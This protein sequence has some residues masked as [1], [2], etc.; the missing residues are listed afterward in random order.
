MNAKATTLENHYPANVS[1]ILDSVFHHSHRHLGKCG[2]YNIIF[3]QNVIHHLLPGQ[4][5]Y[6][7]NRFYFKLYREAKLVRLHFQARFGENV[8]I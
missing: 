6:E 4:E 2:G 3:W 8:L 1:L 5:P 7:H